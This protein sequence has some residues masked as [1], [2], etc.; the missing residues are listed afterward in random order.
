[1]WQRPFPR[2]KPAKSKPERNF[3]RETTVLKSFGRSFVDSSD[4]NGLKTGIQII[5]SLPM[6]TIIKIQTNCC[7]LNCSRMQVASADGAR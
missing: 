6:L 3:R 4:K 7:T 1:M 2:I 5:K